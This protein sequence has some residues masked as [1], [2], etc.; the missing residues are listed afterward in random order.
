LRTLAEAGQDFRIMPR[1]AGLV[2]TIS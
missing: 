1:H 2:E